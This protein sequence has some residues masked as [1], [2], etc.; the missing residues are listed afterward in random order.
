MVDRC[1]YSR[2]IAGRTPSIPGPW[3]VLAEGEA[4]RGIT[5]RETYQRFAR[6]LRDS[7]EALREMLQQLNSDQK[8]VAGYGSPAKGNTLLNY[9][10]IDTHLLPFTFDKNPLKVGRYTPGTHVPV[11]AVS[12]IAARRP[13]YL[14]ILAWNFADEIIRQQAEFQVRGGRF[15]LPIPSAR[16]V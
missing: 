2:A 16:I 1:G 7:R 10:G 4:A 11:L 9:C 15:I 8:L 6:D 12:E 5:L 13:D 3:G 14:L